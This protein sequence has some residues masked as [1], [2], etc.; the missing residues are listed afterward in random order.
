MDRKTFIQFLLISMVIMTVWYLVMGQRLPSR[1]VEP[2]GQPRAAPQEPAPPA[3][4]DQVEPS[5]PP[6]E[7]TVEQPPPPEKAVE[8][9]P[10]IILSNELISTSWTNVGAGLEW[11]QLLQYR[12]PYFEERDGQKTRPVLTLVKEFQEGYRSD[13]IER[14]T[15]RRGPGHQEEKEDWGLDVSTA[16]VV[17]EVVESSD[18]RIVF[19]GILH[20]WLK[21]RKTVSIEPGTYN[22]DVK[23]EFENRTDSDLAFSYRLR[24]AAGIERETLESRSIASAVGWSKGANG[25]SVAQLGAYSI[26]RTEKKAKEAE[27]KGE[28]A[29]SEELLDSLLN[30]SSGVAWAGTFGQYFA[31]LAQPTEP[32]QIAGVES[33]SVTDADILEGLGRWKPGTMSPKQER[34]RADLARSNACAIIHFKALKVAAGNGETAARAY[35]FITAPKLPEALEP[36]GRG[37]T[38]AVRS[39]SVPGF[40]RVLS[41]GTISWVSPVMLGI[42]KFFHWIIPNYGIAILLLTAVVKVGLHPLTRKGQVGMHKMQQLQP[43]IAELRKKFGD[44]KQKMA[45]EQMALFKKYGVHPMSGCLP[46]MLQMPVFI[47]LF[48]TLGSMVELRQAT[49]IPGWITDLSR[50]DTIFHLP[51]YLPVLGNEVNVLPF[52][53]L[54]AWLLNQKFT[55]KPA[56]AQAQQQ[57]KMMK[58]M[59]FVFS[60]MLYHL[61]SGLLLYWTASS[62]FGI[63]EQWLIRR[64]LAGIKLKPVAEEEAKARRG[65]RARP[66]PEKPGFF[67]RLTQ[68]LEEQSKKSGRARSGKPKKRS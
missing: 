18:S 9:V 30:K 14:I 17:Y 50:P 39:A 11:V 37:I 19:E 25:Y 13:V 36:Y 60:I 48:V 5:E 12:A 28:L 45:Q 22:F 24:G 6:E 41:L 67:G 1:Q 33:R 38:K 29:R 10:R 42:L 63:L 8:V 32:G 15:F 7:P 61:A 47:A 16:G 35:R 65:D 2:D 57:Q 55:P 34:T 49:F 3:A 44:D 56:D 68:S 52:L 51:F 46:M 64:S 40:S 59:P 43:K 62:A 23:L 4:T 53:M 21:V 20:R 27:R 66:A 31:A 26:V 54:A 58:F